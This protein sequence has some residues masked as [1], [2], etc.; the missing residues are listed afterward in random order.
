MA[1]KDAAAPAPRPAVQVA[2]VPGVPREPAGASVE[3]EKEEEQQQLCQA[4]S[5]ALLSVEDVDK[6]DGEQPQLCSEYV[7]EIYSYLRELEVM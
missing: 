6:Q 7:K 4:F 3:E 1:Q 2:A 5:A